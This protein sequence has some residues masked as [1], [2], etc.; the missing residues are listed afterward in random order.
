M[1]NSRLLFSFLV[2][3]ILTGSTLSA[4]SP[5]QA[6][7]LKREADSYFK[8]WDTTT[9]GGVAIAVI[10]E[11][12]VVYSNAFGMAN[13]EYNVPNR[14][15]T[16]FHAA[17]LSKQF[18]AYAI[19][20]LES[21]G[22]LSLDDD[23]RTYIPEVPDFGQKITLRQMANHSSGLR[24]QWR[25]LHLSG[26]RPD[27]VVLN[28]DIIDLVAQQKELNFTP[29]SKLMY[30]NTGFTLL[31]EVVAR[32][33]GQSFAEFTRSNIFEPLQMDN[34]QFFDD[35]HKIVE[36]RAY[37][38]QTEAENLF[39]DKL[40][41]S[42]VGAT[43]L[44]T[45][46]MDLIK[47]VIHL[48]N[49]QQNNTELGRK[50]NTNAHLNNGE[51][52]EAAMGQWRGSKY[53]GMEWIDHT[54]SDASFRSYLS[55]FPETNSGVVV[56][57]NITPI[58]AS[59]YGLTIANL[60]LNE[61]FV[62]SEGLSQKEPFDVVSN[63]KLINLKPAE[64]NLFCGNYWQPE[65]RYN[66]EIKLVNDTLIYYRSESSQTKLVPVGKSEFKMLGDTN[67]ASV[68]FEKGPKGKNTM[69]LE[70][71]NENKVI[72]FVKFEKD[73]D[74]ST[75]PG[76][77]YSSEIDASLDFCEKD[78]NLI[79]KLFKYPPVSLEP[80]TVDL[81]RSRDKNLKKIEFVRNKQGRI[82]GLLVSNGG[83]TNLKYTRI[84]AGEL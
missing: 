57:A 22:K 25:L 1:N 5:D 18:T 75:Y 80:V 74:L 46:V 33:S 64:L 28:T 58:N 13:L 48:N 84:D 34:S 3:L 15:N 44:F 81:F 23:I 60:F 47:W 36:N 52:T 40:S 67:D 61:F 50:M 62:E 65:E 4:Q 66:R 59:A 68:F 78:G 26:W 30:S 76:K 24:D 51:L 72:P 77:Y 32:V 6:S 17:S 37:S 69:R 82:T 27:D 73:F 53:Q 45:T 79:V 14:V 19:L 12:K 55:R 10:K 20:L 11:G 21:Q 43:N 56:L 42:T 2:G 7:A 71:I 8:K 39:K 38:Y 83:I 16:V 41:F 35:Y 54:G 9:T 31:A 63:Y 70:I 29:G 49:I